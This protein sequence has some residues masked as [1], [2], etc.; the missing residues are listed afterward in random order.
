M[1]QS[2]KKAFVFGIVSHVIGRGWEQIKLDVC[3]MNLPVTILGVGPGL[4]Y[5]NDGPTHHGTED[6]ALTRALPNMTIFNPCDGNSMIA[7]V[8]QAYVIEGPT[9][10][11]IDRENIVPIHSENA[12]LTPGFKVWREGTKLALVTTGVITHRVLEAARRLEASGIDCQ[13]V[14]LYR[15][16]PVNSKDIVTAFGG[17]ERIVVVDEHSPVGGLATIVAEAV[18]REGVVKPMEIVSLPDQFL[19][20]LI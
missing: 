19:L 16:K 20:G 13:V 4:S 12:N 6:V 8:K 7:A 9:Y 2:G 10:I 3:T 14:E 11:R 17:A 5:G 15:L 18:V 1:A